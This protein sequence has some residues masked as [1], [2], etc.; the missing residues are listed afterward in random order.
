MK[1]GVPAE[2]TAGETRV[3]VTPEKAK[4]RKAQGLAVCVASGAGIA[5]NIPDDAYREAGAEITDQSTALGCEMV[6]KVRAPREGEFAAFQRGAVLVG[7]LDPFDATGAA[8]LA[9]A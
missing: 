1:I 8:R 7:M 3:A 6:L 5:A 2:I 9:S 4:K